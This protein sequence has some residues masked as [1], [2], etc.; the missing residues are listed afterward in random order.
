MARRRRENFEKPAY[1]G[2]FARWKMRFYPPGRGGGVENL[3]SA[4]RSQ[5]LRFDPPLVNISDFA[6]G[7]GQT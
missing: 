4:V 1:T 3:V 5:T 6:K 2:D 7:G